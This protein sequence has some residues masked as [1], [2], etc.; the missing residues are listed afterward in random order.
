[1]VKVQAGVQNISSNWTK[2]VQ[3]AAQNYQLAVSALT[4]A[5]TAGP[6]GQAN[7]LQASAAKNLEVT[8][9]ALEQV[10]GQ[11]FDAVLSKEDLGV[12]KTAAQTVEQASTQAAAF[13][14]APGVVVQKND[15]GSPYL[16]GQEMVAQA[17]KEGKTL[18]RLLDNR[19][20]VIGPGANLDTAL[21][22]WKDAAPAGQPDN[23]IR[24]SAGGRA[25]TEQTRTLTA[26]VR[27][28][29]SAPDAAAWEK[30][31]ARFPDMTVNQ[32]DD[33]SFYVGGL[34]DLKKGGVAQGQTGEGSTAK[35]AVQDAMRRLK[36][37]GARLVVMN[38][39]NER[40]ELTFD[41][42]KN[43][44]I[45]WADRGKVS[46]ADVLS[47]LGGTD[48]IVWQK[49]ADRF[50][51][52]KVTKGDNGKFSV[53][54]MPEQKQ[55]S[56]LRSLG[57]EGSS[58]GGAAKAALRALAQPWARIVVN[59]QSENRQEL[60]WDP[61][62]KDLVP[63]MDHLK[64]V[65]GKGLREGTTEQDSINGIKKALEGIQFPDARVGALVRNLV[66]AEG[67]PYFTKLLKE[68]AT[69]SLV[70]EAN[71]RLSSDPAPLLKMLQGVPKDVQ[72]AA[73]KD[74]I[75]QVKFPQGLQAALA[76]LEAKT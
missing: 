66:A 72:T 52:L 69:S 4:A 62:K 39:S 60:T 65:V 47:E 49:M 50:P 36:D 24:F 12:L 40:Q 35:D 2:G 73:L 27:G 48:A 51:D 57:V 1:M 5:R 76:Q 11:R 53:D 8:R 13:S 29:L 75:P 61:A 55:G 23:D 25:N 20:L 21:Q 15:H 22:A 54:G 32:R 37:P 26:A 71:N 68:E 14:F 42:K 3:E 56:M 44:F 45:P 59:P 18:G 7:G 74:A 64:A 43:D 34:P 70:K 38:D 31:N 9:G 6:T 63:Y 33:G 41:L 16:Q 17:N 19:P 28:E 67:A 10:L 58:M 46:Q 30:L